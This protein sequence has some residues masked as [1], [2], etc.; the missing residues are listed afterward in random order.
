MILLLIN[1]HRVLGAW[2]E[3]V[4]LALNKRTHLRQLQRTKALAR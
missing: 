4:L 2:Q 1:V 3:G